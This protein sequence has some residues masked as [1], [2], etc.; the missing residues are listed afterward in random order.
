MLHVDINSSSDERTNGLTA[1]PNVPRLHLVSVD[2]WM[3]EYKE[4]MSNFM[5]TSGL[6]DTQRS[7]WV[8]GW[9]V[10]IVETSSEVLLVEIFDEA[11]NLTGPDD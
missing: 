8:S 4:W 6:M 3:S 10:Q 5:D 1:K 7:E 9:N 11:V 2:G